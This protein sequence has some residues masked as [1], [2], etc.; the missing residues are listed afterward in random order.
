MSAELPAPGQNKTWRQRLVLILTL[1]L[2][3]LL[4][5]HPELRIFLPLLD[6]LGLELLL[7]IM[8][9]Q[10]IDFVRPGYYLFVRYVAG[11]LA[12][13][14]YA[15]VLF[16]FGVAGPF[17]GAWASSFIASQRPLAKTAA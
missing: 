12:A 11:P 14:L 15:L 8:A 16:L 2:V 17:V 1:I 10:V 13:R 4:M 7:A 9:S 3:V 5:M 6:A